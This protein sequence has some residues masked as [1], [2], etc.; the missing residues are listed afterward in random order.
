MKLRYCY[1]Y[2]TFSRPGSDLITNLIDA[3]PWEFVENE[4]AKVEWDGLSQEKKDE[5]GFDYDLMQYLLKC[6]ELHF[7]VDTLDLQKSG[8]TRGAQ[9]PAS[10]WHASFGLADDS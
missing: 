4:G 8:Q 10:G 9:G 5:W 7:E 6:L 2:K 3:G 1:D